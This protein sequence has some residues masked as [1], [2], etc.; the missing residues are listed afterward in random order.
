MGLKRINTF[1]QIIRFRGK[2]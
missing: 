2:N 1:T